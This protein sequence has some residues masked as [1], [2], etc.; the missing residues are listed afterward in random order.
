MHQ[1]MVTLFSQRRIM[2]G[3]KLMNTD[4]VLFCYIQT[5][6]ENITAVGLPRLPSAV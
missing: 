3:Q 1:R 6:Q 4:N 5:F 2:T